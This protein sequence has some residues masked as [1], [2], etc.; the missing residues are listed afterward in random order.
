MVEIDLGRGFAYPLALLPD[1]TM[2][3]GFGEWRQPI[4]HTQT[5][6]REQVVGAVEQFCAETWPTAHHIT[7]S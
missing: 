4:E 5:R 6:R 3:R 1:G 2:G 7:R